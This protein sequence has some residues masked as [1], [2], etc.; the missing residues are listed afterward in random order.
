MCSHSFCVSIAQLSK[1]ASMLLLMGLL[2]VITRLETVLCS[3]TLNTRQEQKGFLLTSLKEVVQ[4]VL[5][6][7]NDC[8]VLRDVTALHDLGGQCLD[9][10]HLPSGNLSII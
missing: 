5:M 4:K 6:W 1:P 7:K 2:N 10:V 9:M 8:S 3:D